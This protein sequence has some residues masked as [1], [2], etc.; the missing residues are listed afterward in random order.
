MSDAFLCGFCGKEMR[1]RRSEEKYI[2]TYWCAECG[3]IVAAY[4]KESERSLMFGRLFERYSVHQYK[5]EIP[6]YVGPVEA[7]D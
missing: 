4:L 7:Q 2:V 1:P 6:A 3:R 5:P